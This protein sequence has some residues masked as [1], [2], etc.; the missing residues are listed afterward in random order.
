MQPILAKARAWLALDRDAATRSEVQQYI[1]GNDTKAL[2]AILD[3]RIAFGTAGLRARMQAGFGRMNDVTVLQA[4]QGVLAHLL[5]VVPDVHTR[6]VVIGHDHRHH[7]QR[8]AARAA[9]VFLRAGVPVVLLRGLACT[10]MVPFGVKTL[11]AAAGIMIT[12]SHNPKDDNGYKLYWSNAVQIVSPVDKRVA[13]AI[14]EHLDLDDAA[15]DLSVLSQSIDRTAE[16]R[17]QYIEQVGMLSRFR[18]E[19]AQSIQKVVYTPMHGVGFEYAQA[20]FVAFG[21]PKENLLSVPEQQAPDPDFPTVAFPNPEEQGALRL[22]TAFADAQGASL[23][24]ANDPDADRF[25]AAE[26]SAGHWTTFTGDQIGAIFA[27]W[28]FEQYKAS[29]RPIEKLAMLAS[30]ASSKLVAAM[31]K[32][33]GFYFDETLTGFKYLGNRALDLDQQGYSC[34]FAYEEAIGYMNGS[35]IRDKDGI[36]ALA[37]FAELS[38]FLSRKNST[39]AQ[40]LEQIY[41]RYGHFVTS[42]SYFIC[43]DPSKLAAI[44]RR[45]RY[46]ETDST[47]LAFPKTIGGIPIESIR[48]LT[49]GYDSTR[50]PDFKP[51]LPVS[52][53]SQMITLVTRPDAGGTIGSVTATLRGSGT[54]PKVS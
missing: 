53:N 14:E 32:A 28:A 51:V 23:V 50:P 2:H 37:I 12:A 36:S 54:E 17:Q 21:F 11:G 45:I 15:W 5:Q 39:V 9:T 25:C 29:G 26:K 10:P 33:E 3:Q 7:S 22:A 42:N 43:R 8:F 1:D 20:A 44:F 13:A 46:S 48:D 19:N 24:L 34:E 38:A 4:T 47:E 6:G 18:G 49:V 35:I 27:M 41:Q 40:Y 30:T 16:L 31:A 52:S